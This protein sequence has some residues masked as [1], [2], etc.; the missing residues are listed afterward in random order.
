M[1]KQ[2]SA[3]TPESQASVPFTFDGGLLS[4]RLGR[5]GEVCLK[6]CQTWHEETTRFLTRRFERDAELAT[7][8]LGCRD[9]SDAM[10]LQQEWASAAVQDYLDQT[11]RVAE[12]A[13]SFAGTLEPGPQKPAAPRQSD[14]A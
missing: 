8:L 12:I 13:G 11:R 9:L 10:R 6:A 7:R 5:A 4:E 2:F 1:T 14:A 3:K